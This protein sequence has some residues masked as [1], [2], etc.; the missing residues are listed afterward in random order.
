V[1]PPLRPFGE[2]ELITLRSQMS[3]LRL[4]NGKT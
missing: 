4:L 3:Q 1:L 2:T